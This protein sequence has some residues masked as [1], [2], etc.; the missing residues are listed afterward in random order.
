MTFATAPFGLQKVLLIGILFAV[1]VSACDLF[2]CLRRKCKPYVCT[3][4]E[5]IV[6][7]LS[8][9]ALINLMSYVSAS[10]AGNLP[11]TVA[12][13]IGVPVWVYAV[14]E[15]LMLAMSVSAMVLGRRADRRH[16]SN[17]SV[18]ESFDNLP[19]GICFYE[20]SGILRLVNVKINDLCVEI[21]GKPLLNGAEFW[22]TLA[23]DA[24]I[25]PNER[26]GTGETPMIKTERGK[27]YSFNRTEHAVDGE[28]VFEIVA[29][30]ITRRY[31]LS[32]DLACKNEELAA[33]NQRMREY[34]E[35][36]QELTA[37]RETLNAK[38]RI[39]DELGKLL[40]F[41]RKSLSAP[42]TEEERRGMLSSWKNDVIA[43]G[44]AK[45]GNVSDT[46]S[47]LYAAAK[48]AGVAV[49]ITGRKPEDKTLKKIVVTAAIECVTNAV[50]H[51]KGNVVNV[52]LEDKGAFLNIYVSNNGEPPTEKIKEGG[53]FSSLR[54]L[55]EREGG[56]M[57][58]TSAP[59]FGLAI[60]VPKGGKK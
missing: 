58:I 33:F 30:D 35:K 19:S 37:E 18:K 53:G 57:T 4:V 48:S 6:L 42:M 39:H 43:F 36:I 50:K 46:Y 60:T 27:V 29:T 13:V 28:A 1:A 8:A 56:K 38:I 22:K 40:L 7:I 26:V 32:E 45:G 16:I 54:P 21:T 14:C 3:A 49:K 9:V 24:P 12:R 51:A 44:S 25:A 41:T 55:V 15:P 34:G 20:T 47:G 11:E 52:E 23:E 5:L 31:R 10:G 59:A 2:L 17:M